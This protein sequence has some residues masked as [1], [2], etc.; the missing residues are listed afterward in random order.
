GCAESGFR[1]IVAACAK[2]AATANRRTASAFSRSA[3]PKHRCRIAPSTPGL[4]TLAPPPQGRRDES[5]EPLAILPRVLQREAR[6]E[7]RSPWK[8]RAAGATGEAM[9]SRRNFFAA[10]PR[11]RTAWTQSLAL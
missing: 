6:A 5:R 3:R 7:A 1:L 10:M 11:T 4:R 2:G 9:I 8:T